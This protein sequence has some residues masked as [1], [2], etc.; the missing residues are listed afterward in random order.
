[1][2]H[3]TSEN[4]LMKKWIDFVKINCHLNENIR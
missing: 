1:M 4:Q 3:T 2:F